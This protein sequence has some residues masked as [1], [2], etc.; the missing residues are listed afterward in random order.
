MDAE[1]SANTEHNIGGEEFNHHLPF[2]NRHYFPVS[3]QMMERTTRERKRKTKKIL[4]NV[5]AKMSV[6]WCQSMDHELGK[7]AIILLPLCFAACMASVFPVGLH[8]Q[9]V[10]HEHL[11]A[12]VVHKTAHVARSQYHSQDNF[13]QYSYGYAEP[14]GAKK[15]TRHADGTVVDLVI[16]AV[17]VVCWGQSWDT[18]AIGSRLSVSRV[19]ISSSRDEGVDALREVDV[20]S[21]DSI[22]ADRVGHNGSGHVVGGLD[23]GREVLVGGRG[24]GRAEAVFVSDVVVGQEGAIGQRVLQLRTNNGAVS[25]TSLLLGT[26]GLGVSVAVLPEVVLAV[27]LTACHVGSL[28]DHGCHE[29]LVVHVLLVETNRERRIRSCTA[30]S[31]PGCGT[32]C[33]PRGQSCGPRVPRGARGARTACGDRQGTRW[34]C[35]QRSTTATRSIRGYTDTSLSDEYNAAAETEIPRNL[36]TRSWEV[37]VD[38]LSEVDVWSWD[39]IGADRVRQNRGG[40]VIGGLDDGQEVLGGGRGQGRA[41][42]VFVSDV[43]VGQDGAIWQRCKG[44]FELTSRCQQRYGEVDV[45][46]WDGIGADRV[47]QNRG[48]HVIGGLDDGQEVLGGGRGQGRAEAV[49]VSDVVVGQDGAI[50]QGVPVK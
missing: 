6:D 47:R 4:L 33:V 17:C 31:C 35:R 38:S 2:A 48:G 39:G 7:T 50:G 30:R 25:M 15:E 29:V 1:V 5:P 20:G 3:G 34:P 46:S 49:F 40:H 23:D 32:D 16:F 24:Q 43:V 44:D 21:C 27:V 28:V 37:R 19:S 10:H 11:V 9:Y 42:A 22:G 12:P 41:E 13:G 18:V 26:V 45:W 14:N 36:E 8:K